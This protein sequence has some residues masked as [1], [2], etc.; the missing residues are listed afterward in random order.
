MQHVLRSWYSHAASHQ[1]VLITVILVTYSLKKYNHFS[2]KG[3]TINGYT[4]NL[5]PDAVRSAFTLLSLS[6]R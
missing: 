5:D 2:D 4:Y 6:L 1:N 3:H